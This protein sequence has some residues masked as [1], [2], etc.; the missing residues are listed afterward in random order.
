MTPAVEF[1]RICD[2]VGGGKSILDAGCAFGRDSAMFHGEG[3]KVVGIDMSDELLK[4]AF[5]LSPDIDFK[6]MGIRD[7]KFSDNS[8]DG[9]RCHATLLHLTDEDILKAYRSK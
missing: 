3:Y 8:F 6:K 5:A 9:I 4:K 7:L 2:E 1:R